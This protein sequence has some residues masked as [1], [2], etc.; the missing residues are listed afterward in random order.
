[1][2]LPTWFEEFIKL[3]VGIR[4]KTPIGTISHII[5][6]FKCSIIMEWKFFDYGN[7]KN[8]SSLKIIESSIFRKKLIMR[9]LFLR[10]CK[11]MN[12]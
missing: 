11:V 6:C 2:L 8:V 7:I 4:A 9:G 10:G 3:D 12:H 5:Y 1:M